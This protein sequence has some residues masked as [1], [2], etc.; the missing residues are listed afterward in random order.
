[1]KYVLFDLD[2]TL[3]PLDTDDFIKKYLKLLSEKMAHHIEPNIFVP[4]LLKAT[5]AMVLNIGE[6]TNEEVFIENFFQDSPHNKEFMMK[7]FEKFYSN[8]YKTLKIYSKPNPLAIEILDYL[9]SK[10]IG[11]IIA[12]NPVFP[13]IAIKERM[14]WVGLDKFKFKL[15]TSY[16][17]MKA[18]KPQLQYYQQ[19][20]DDLSILPEKCL[21]VGNDIQ[22]DMIAGKLG[23]KTFL[24]EDYLIDNRTNHIE[25]TFRGSF[26]EM[27]NYIMELV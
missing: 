27:R 25:P 5:E 7:E 17:N 15:I 3:L 1:M 8:E 18:C 11:V 14:R 9:N 10:D 24:V 26:G 16:E 21:M 2:G 23:M 13:I 19:I 4:K 6:R 20:L 22:E 12:T